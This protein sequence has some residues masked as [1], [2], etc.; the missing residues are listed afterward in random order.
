MVA[1]LQNME[2]GEMRLSGDCR[3]GGREGFVKVI[4]YRF[5]YPY[6]FPSPY[7]AYLIPPDLVKGERV[8]LEDVIEDIVFVFGNQGYHPRLQAW[9][10]TWD[11]K[12]FEIHFNPET[13]AHHWL[14]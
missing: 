1:V 7:A 11:G 8:W 5:Y 3:W 2:T 10:A 9:E 13:D 14:G 12:D 4:D 6:H